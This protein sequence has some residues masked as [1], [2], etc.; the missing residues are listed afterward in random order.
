MQRR[1]KLALTG[2]AIALG[3]FV[4][5]QFLV[6]PV[7]DSLQETRSNLPIQ[8]KKLEKYREVAR[9]APIRTGEVATVETRLRQAESGLLASMTAALASAEL[10]DLVTQLA[11]KERIDLHANTFLPVKAVSPEYAT[12][13][14]TVQF[15]CRLDQF[16][17]LLRDFS[18]NPKYLTVSKLSIQPTAAKDKSVS[19]GL[20]VAGIMLA[21][22][23][24]RERAH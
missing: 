6:F 17:S 2:G 3:L 14:M 18:D 23:T 16:M 9:T 8:Q 5:F 22:T 10:Q 7:W 12:V 20:E 1:N 4:V 15:Q 24:S 21:E 19:V 11:D 13:P